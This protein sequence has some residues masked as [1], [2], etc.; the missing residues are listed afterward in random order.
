MHVKL[1][2]FSRREIPELYECVRI[3]TFD[4]ISLPAVDIINKPVN[5]NLQQQ[6]DF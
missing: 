3:V 1:K 4:V 5:L 6:Y 2:K